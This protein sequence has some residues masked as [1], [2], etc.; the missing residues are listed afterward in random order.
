MWECGEVLTQNKSNPVKGNKGSENKSVIEKNGG[1]RK[2][3]VVK[4]ARGAALRAS[5]RQNRTG[6][7]ERQ[8]TACV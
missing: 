2:V 7:A 1:S 6:A 3:V 5:A 8:E 4:I